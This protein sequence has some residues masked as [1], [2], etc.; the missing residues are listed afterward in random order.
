LSINDP[1]LLDFLKQAGWLES[2]NSV[3]P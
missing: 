3:R 2:T 1:R